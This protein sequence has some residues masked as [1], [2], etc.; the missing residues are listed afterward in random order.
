MQR[1]G[2]KNIS[3]KKAGVEQEKEKLVQ[4]TLKEL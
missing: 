2:K 1:R 4:R 3:P